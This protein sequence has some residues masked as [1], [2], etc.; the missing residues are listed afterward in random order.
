MT[1]FL[2]V[3]IRVRDEVFGNLY[4]AGKHPR[5]VHRRGRGAGHR[6]GRDRRRGDRQRSSLRDRPHPRRVAAGDRH[7][8]QPPAHHRPARPH[9]TPAPDRRPRPRR[10]P[11]RPGHRHPPAT[12]P[13]NGGE[14]ELRAAVAV[15]NAADLVQGL[16]TP[17]SGSVSGHVFRSGQA[18]RLATPDEPPTIPSAASPGLDAGPALAVPLRGRTGCTA[19]S[20]P[21]GYAAAPCSPPRT[22]RWPLGSPTRP[23]SPSSSPGPA[24]TG[25][26][27]PCSTTGS[28][29]PPTCRPRHPAPVRH[30]PVPAGPCRHA[31]LRPRD[32][33]RA[34]QRGRS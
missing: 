10:R 5:A 17:L 27:P 29:S 15:G 8:H 11:R 21:C 25:S 2:G 19:C 14:T 12:L 30:R 33:P 23:P 34:A 7:D 6:P 13:G 24:P 4:L 18:L 9:R 16:P 20:P 26:A 22:S 32:G 31:R 28:A 1:S 3:P